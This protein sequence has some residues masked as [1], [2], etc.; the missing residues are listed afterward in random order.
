MWQPAV[1]CQG[2]LARLHI[3][4]SAWR[5]RTVKHDRA[6]LLGARDFCWMRAW[7]VT[8]LS[9]KFP[10]LRHTVHHCISEN[11]GPPH[12][13]TPFTKIGKSKA[14]LSRADVGCRHLCNLTNQKQS[15]CVIPPYD[16]TACITHRKASALKISAEDTSAFRF[17]FPAAQQEGFCTPCRLHAMNWMCM[18]SQ[19]ALWA[20]CW[21]Q[22]NGFATELAW[23]PGWSRD[24]LHMW[25][26]DSAGRWLLGGSWALVLAQSSSH[27]I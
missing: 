5:G 21:D 10:P 26:E 23:W 1:P 13:Y 6:F 27:T 16:S 17:S 22:L 24:R 7:S 25:G 8:Y 11:W 19:K 4:P 18:G 14:G 12:F 20:L 2:A 3:N 9:Y 15:E